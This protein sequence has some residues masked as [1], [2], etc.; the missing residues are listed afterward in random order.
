MIGNIFDVFLNVASM[1][2]PNMPSS[3]ANSVLLPTV[4]VDSSD[5]LVSV[6]VSLPLKYYQAL[7][8]LVTKNK[9]TQYESALYLSYRFS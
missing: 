2:Y 6:V 9:G 7:F 4:A 1:N 8:H 3:V 5:F